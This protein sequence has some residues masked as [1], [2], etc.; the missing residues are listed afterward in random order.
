MLQEGANSAF[1]EAI[2]DT[3]MLGVL[4]PRHLFKLGILDPKIPT[5]GGMWPLLIHLLIRVMPGMALSYAINVSFK[6][7]R[8]S[9]Y[10]FSN[11][12]CFISFIIVNILYIVKC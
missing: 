12:F 6:I 5:E 1:Q 2:G 11:V 3:V 10:Q 8:V 7:E 9:V 4:S